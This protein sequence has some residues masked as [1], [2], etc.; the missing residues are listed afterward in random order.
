MNGTNLSPVIAEL[1]LAF[2]VIAFLA[3]IRAIGNPV[4][5]NKLLRDS[6]HLELGNRITLASAILSAL[7]WAVLSVLLTITVL[8]VHSSHLKSYLGPMAGCL[9]L[10][11]IIAT[12]SGYRRRKRPD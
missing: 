12:Y 11:W 1:L 4:F 3:S 5:R 10:A 9:L 8:H 2:S 7:W 6:R